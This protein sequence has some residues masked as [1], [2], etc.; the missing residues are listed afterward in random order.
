MRL[1]ILLALGSLLAGSAFAQQT[2]PLSVETSNPGG[3]AISGVN[4]SSQS[5]S[6]GLS[7][8]GSVGV[9]GEG[10]AA[11]GQFT[12]QVGTGI[13]VLGYAA[14]VN[15]TCLGASC[16]AVSGSASGQGIPGTGVYGIG[17]VGI[18][19]RSRPTNFGINLPV[20]AGVFEGNVRGDSGPERRRH[21]QLTSYSG[22]EGSRGLADHPRRHPGSG[23]PVTAR[24]RSCRLA[25]ERRPTISAVRG[26][27]T[28][29]ALQATRVVPTAMM[30][31]TSRRRSRAAMP[32]AG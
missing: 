31:S 14:G 28:S 13:S 4:T 17:S 20:Y 12:S 7:G 30:T 16:T 10:G 18:Y 27:A 2:T 23:Q 19:G 3:S 1:A 6:A 24:E 9:R 8:R 25:C 32:S 26:S 11:A 21:A 15:S 29:T 5:T 22:V